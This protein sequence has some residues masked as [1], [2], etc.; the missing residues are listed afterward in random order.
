MPAT[1]SSHA[2]A[3][4]GAR[5]SFLERLGAWAFGQ[6]SWTPVP[7]ALI[8]VFIRWHWIH[9]AWVLDLGLLIVVA[10]LAIRYWAVSYIGTI[11]RTRAARFGPLMSAGPFAL[12]R[13]P[14]YVGNFL[15]WIGFVIASGLMWMLPV[16]WALF[17]LQY[18]AIV[19]FEEVALVQHFGGSY[20]KYLREVPR[21]T[22]RLRRLDIAL[23]TRGPHGWREICFSERGTLIAAGV[24]TVLLIAKWRGV[25]G[26]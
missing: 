5:R 25:L 4:P 1:S 11:S 13:N 12:V 23:S 9:E 7:L 17:A 18:S 6:R 16:A 3:D 2:T 26:F 22:L 15:I 21:W 24:M 19:R 20:E 10:G 14:L 8:L